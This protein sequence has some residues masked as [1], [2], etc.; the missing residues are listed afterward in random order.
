M[1]QYHDILRSI[2]EHGTEHKDR[3]GVG[4]ISHFGFQTRFDLRQGFPIVTTKRVP[5]RWIA[6]ELFWFLSGDTNEANLRARGVDIW[7]EWAD[8]EHTRRFGREAGDLGPVYGYLW[9]SFGGH[10][11]QTDGVDQI[12]RLINEIER[13]PNSRRLIVSGWDPRECDNVDL[14]PCHT[15][16]Q[17]KVEHA[18]ALSTVPTLHCQLYQRSADAF[19]G[20]PFNISSYALLTHLVAHV[21]GLQVGEFI[22]TLGDYHIY[23]NHLEQ[24]N[25]LLAREPLI[26]P[27][28]E[29]SD[30]ANRSRGLEGLLNIRF[31]NLKLVAYKSH[32]KIAGQ[33]AV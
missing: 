27:T 24:V 7:K 8:A 14:P 30:E 15:L 21:C 33:V 22:Y 18:G 28:L 17:F 12:A 20:V 9:R 25:E 29:I 23:R 11:P 13:N 10:Y 19:L 6:E 4:T 2:L 5:F 32:A 26:L 31:E 3:T 1:K 16:F